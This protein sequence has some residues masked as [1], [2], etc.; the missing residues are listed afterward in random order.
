MDSK[1]TDEL[2]KIAESSVVLTIFITA[3][4]Y[5]AAY[6]YNFGYLSQFGIPANF[7][8]I[9]IPSLIFSIGIVL[10]TS[11]TAFTATTLFLDIGKKIKKT[12]IKLI[13]WTLII[14]V[15][16]LGI[17]TAAGLLKWRL[18]AAVLLSLVVIF[19]FTYLGY[20]VREKNLKT[21]WRTFIKNMGAR[22]QSKNPLDLLPERLGLFLALSILITMISFG[23]GVIN[24]GIKNVF[25]LVEMQGDKR[26]LIV[27]VNNQVVITKEYDVNTKEFTQGYS[28]V[29]LKDLNNVK[30]FEKRTSSDPVSGWLLD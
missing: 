18:I 17:L 9:S 21:A 1:K 13:Y 10:L 25:P 11:I 30:S 20:V 4:G 5:A 27:S 19:F 12:S 26:I 7:I 8:D 16:S 28:F 6:A 2:K 15:F 22:D 14:L 29:E 3:I 23:I 24:G